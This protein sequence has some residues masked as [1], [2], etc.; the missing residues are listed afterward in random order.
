VQTEV[1]A[2]GLG[3]WNASQNRETQNQKAADIQNDLNKLSTTLTPGRSDPSST[4]PGA[5]SKRHST[6]GIVQGEAKS[7]AESRM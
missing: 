2:H 3:A 1:A 5:K 4:S 7:T 6:T